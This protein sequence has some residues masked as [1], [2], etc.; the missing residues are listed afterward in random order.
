VNILFLSLR[1]PYPPQRGDRIR[2][3][4]F[5]RGLAERHRVSLVCFAD[6][7]SDPSLNTSMNS[8]HSSGDRRGEPS[9]PEEFC[10]RVWRVPY[11]RWEG[12][13]RAARSVFQ[14]TPLQNGLW[15]SNAMARTVSEA[16]QTTAPD[17]IQAQFFRMAPYALLGS[18]P[19]LLDLAD[20]MTMNLQRRLE[21][22]R[23]PL[24]RLLVGAEHRRVRSYEPQIA[25]KFDRALVCA[26]EDRDVLRALDPTLSLDVLTHG[27]DLD[28]FSPSEAKRADSSSTLLF[29]GTMD[30]FP[31]VDAVK[32]LGES[33]LPRVRTRVPDV[34]L[35]VVGRDPSPSVRRWGHADGITVTGAVP[36]VRPYFEGAAV[37]VSPLRCG[38]GMQFKN[39]EA[40]AMGVPLVT[41]TYG[42]G[43]LLA[44]PNRDYV[45]ADAPEVIADAIV[46]L[47][48]DPHERRRLAANGRAYVEREHHWSRLTDRLSA[49]HEE[50]TG[51]RRQDVSA[52]GRKADTEEKIVR[53]A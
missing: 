5:L 11:P 17:T 8:G 23:N 9:R 43:G 29:T 36:D 38:S 32:F 13:I 4:Y 26:P 37:Y 33:I 52:L 2:S 12:R 45:R 21:R 40:M 50:M 41:T 44:A 49:M 20:A 27:V 24:T 51:T 15:Y 30:Y 48:R 3:Y 10:A 6:G 31:N 39:L 53:T 18:A 7:E 1:F 25:Q 47:L 34:Q 22:E 14:T 35:L 46:R 28:Y 16:L 42:S 19:K